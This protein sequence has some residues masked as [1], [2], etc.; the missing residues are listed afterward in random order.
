MSRGMNGQS[1][2]DYN[3]LRR[4]SSQAAGPASS[5]RVDVVST[6]CKSIETLR[7]L[8][9]RLS[10]SPDY[11]CPNRQHSEDVRYTFYD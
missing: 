3:G 2:A 4:R 8:L 9:S 7:A 5:Y 10:Q 11:D 6:F 1:S